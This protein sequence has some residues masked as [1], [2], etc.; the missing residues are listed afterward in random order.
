MTLNHDRRLAP[1]LTVS[2]AL[3]SLFFAAAA[4]TAGPPEA[5]EVLIPLIRFDAAATAEGWVFDPWGNGTAAV[6]LAQGSLKLEWEKSATLANHALIRSL[7]PLWKNR[8]P[9]REFYMRYKGD[10][11]GSWIYFYSQT[12]HEGKQYTF[13]RQILGSTDEQWRVQRIPLGGNPE[14][15]GHGVDFDIRELESFCLSCRGTGALSV[16]EI[17][18]VVKYSTLDTEVGTHGDGVVGLPA[19]TGPI[20]IDGSIAEDEWRDATPFNLHPAARDDPRGICDARLTPREPTE[21]LLLWDERG[22]Y[23]AARCF[24]DDMSRIKADHTDN[25]PD[26]HT[27]ECIEIYIDPDRAELL[28]PEMRKFAV[29]ANGKFGVLRFKPE[30]TYDGFTT[31]A[32]QFDDRWEVEFFVPWNVVG[33]TPEHGEFLGFNITRQTWGEAAERSGW[34]TIRWNGIADFRTLVLTPAGGR[35]APLDV[36]V[37]L[38]FIAPGQYVLCST[39]SEG[40]E[41]L[42][43]LKLFEQGKLVMRQAGRC[44]GPVLC[45]WLTNEQLGSPRAYTLRAAICDRDQGSVAVLQ[46]EFVDGQP[47][48]QPP[49]GVDSLALFPVPKTFVSTEA[50]TSL[51]NEASVACASAGLEVCT[52]RLAKELLDFY[53]VELEAAAAVNDATIVLGLVADMQDLLDE[54]RLDTN[55]ARLRHDGFLLRVGADKIIAAAKEKRGVLYATE[56]LIALIKMSS[57]ETGPAR[58]RH[59]KVVDWPRFARRPWMHSMNGWWPRRKYDVGLY[60]RMLETF[61]LAFRYNLFTFML[62]DYYLWPSVPKHE[63]AFAW[64]EDEFAEVVDFVNRNL[65]PVMPHVS[66][67]THMG[68]FLDRVQPLRHLVERGDGFYD[69]RLCTRHPDTYPALFRLYDD[70]LRVCGRNREY[71]SEYFHIQCDELSFKGPPCPRC[72]DIPR[73]RLIGAHLNRIAAYLRDKGKRPVMWCD[74]FNRDRPDSMV[75]LRDQ[76]PRQIV[77][78]GWDPPRDDPEIP[79]FRRNGNEVWKVTTGYRGVSRLNEQH[80]QGRGFLIANYHWWLPFARNLYTGGVYGI[81]AQALVANAAWNEFP[82]N[83]NS[84]WSEY[85]RVYGKWLMHNWSRK[86]LPAAGSGFV[87]IDLADIADEPVRDEQ[88][89]DGTGWFDQGPD[90]DL[91]HMDFNIRAIDG[92]PVRFARKEGTPCCALFRAGQTDRRRVRVGARLG[93]LI[94]LHAASLPPRQAIELKQVLE[95]D[96]EQGPEL[97]VYTVRYQDGTRNRFAVNYGWNV[98]HWLS[99]PTRFGGRR[100]FNNT[101]AT[102]PGVFAKYLPDARS[103]WD[104]HTEEALNRKYPPDIAIYQYEWPNPAPGKTIESIEI[105][106]QNVPHISYALLAVTGRTVRN[107]AQPEE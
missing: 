106:S 69:H 8:Y 27:D 99:D 25:D 52:E 96:P 18:V 97:V 68:E 91:S 90:R 43:T 80:A 59:L 30:E 67:L 70:M 35:S 76:L 16:S 75:A 64:S 50:V 37:D 44:D 14:P 33:M 105:S 13:T 3:I 15:A 46:A 40:R 62:D 11:T 36:P 85:C 71:D 26:M 28:A 17:G 107:P 51:D 58:I 21:V 29:N 49:L 104:G 22:L 61:P 87:A 56:A 72:A 10:F 24:K 42:Y 1:V 47:G 4:V 65:C 45:E 102:L 5:K 103:L 48:T 53:G 57:P 19:A 86:P 89:G 20:R 83:D 74:M 38:G 55:A 66:S 54:Y 34:G 63:N 94:L 41:L 7:A 73:T 31:A 12:Q 84:S 6:T 100:L 79:K 60:K 9:V 39:E 93:S 81:M 78:T 95:S 88:A 92:I 82:D 23:G 98:L 32:R 77:V 101:Y 2:L